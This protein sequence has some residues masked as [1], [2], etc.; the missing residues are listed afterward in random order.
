[1]TFNGRGDGPGSHPVNFKTPE[2]GRI[3]GKKT[4][5]GVL[6]HNYWRENLIIARGNWVAEFDC[7][8]CACHLFAPT[9][10]GKN[11]VFG[12]TGVQ[13]H[14]VS[15][16]WAPPV[17]PNGILTG[18]LLE[19]QLSMCQCTLCTTSV[20]VIMCCITLTLI[21]YERGTRVQY[22]RDETGAQRLHCSLWSSARKGKWLCSS[23]RVVE[24]MLRLEHV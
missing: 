5:W 18:Y 20:I 2:G 14:S 10:P 12:V 4:A 6:I 24:V 8:L 13:K 21:V 22:F 19:Y 7:L 1:M 11:P 16:H 15:L 23:N 9:V 17:E 3:V